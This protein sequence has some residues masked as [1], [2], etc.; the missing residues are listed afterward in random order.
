VVLGIAG[1]ALGG[2]LGLGA[3]GERWEKAE[4]GAWRVSV[5]PTREGVGATVRFSF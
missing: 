2:L 5:A 4:P 3:P 1:A